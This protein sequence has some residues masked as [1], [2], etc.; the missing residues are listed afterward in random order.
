MGKFNKKL[1]HCLYRPTALQVIHL[2]AGDKVF[3][4]KNFYFKLKLSILTLN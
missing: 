4:G 1:I 3:L 2:N